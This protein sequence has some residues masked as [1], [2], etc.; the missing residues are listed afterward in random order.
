MMINH[1][2]HMKN[3]DTYMHMKN[4]ENMRSS[5]SILCECIME[6]NC[7]EC[8]LKGE[9]CSNKPFYTMKNYEIEDIY[10]KYNDKIKKN[11][12]EYYEKNKDESEKDKKLISD[13][14]NEEI[15]HPDRYKS[16]KYECIDVMQDV[17]GTDAVEYFCILN[18]FKYVWRNEKKNGI[19]DIKKA[20]WYLNKYIELEE[21]KNV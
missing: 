15:N 10:N 2:Q 11:R 18:A 14:S 12:K 4:Y 6:H 8:K 17:F 20:V 5:L 7:E 19:E 21:K 9:K 1:E 13:K 16:G 3:Y